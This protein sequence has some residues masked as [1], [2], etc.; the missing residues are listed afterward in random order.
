MIIKKPILTVLFLNAEFLFSH[1]SLFRSLLLLEIGLPV[2]FW[3]SP[4]L[5]GF[6][7]VLVKRVSRTWLNLTW[8]AAIIYVSTI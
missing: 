2:L 6:S 8:P 1:I 4:A 3:Y 7:S 5:L